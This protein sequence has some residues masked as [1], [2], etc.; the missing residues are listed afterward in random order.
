MA[1]DWKD[2]ARPR[3]I[4]L[5]EAQDVKGWEQYLIFLLVVARAPEIEA[6]AREALAAS[7]H[8]AQVYWNGRCE[9]SD[10]L[11]N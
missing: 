10:H 9:C 3:M 2:K 1:D 4:E 6:L 11:L 5:L 8:D 7:S